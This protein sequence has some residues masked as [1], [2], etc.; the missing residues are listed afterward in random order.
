MVHTGSERELYL[1]R[2]ERHH[3]IIIVSQKLFFK[4]KYVLNMVND[5]AAASV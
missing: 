1:V 4:E 5:T 2:V 3:T